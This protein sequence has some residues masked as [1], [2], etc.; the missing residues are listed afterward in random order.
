MFVV[1]LQRIALLISQ[2]GKIYVYTEGSCRNE[3]NMP[4]RAPD[5][6]V[7]GFPNLAL[8]S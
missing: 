3:E 7:V 4:A 8:Q 5:I 6:V 1:I 2:D